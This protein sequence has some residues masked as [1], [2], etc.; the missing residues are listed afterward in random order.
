MPSASDKRR[1][2][3]GVSTLRDGSCRDNAPQRY[4]LGDPFQL[5]RVEVVAGDRGAGCSRTASTAQC[6]QRDDSLSGVSRPSYWRGEGQASVAD[7]V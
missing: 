7:G 5:D 2:C 4:W 6:S 1:L 3:V